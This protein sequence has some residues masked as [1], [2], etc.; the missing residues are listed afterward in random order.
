MKK[1]DEISIMN[2]F[3]G[4]GGFAE[5]NAAKTSRV[6]SKLKGTVPEVIDA[7]GLLNI[8]DNELTDYVDCDYAFIIALNLVFYEKSENQL[9][10]L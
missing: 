6:Y 10:L 7:S 5:K 8:T 4:N 1:A 2:K 3:S 9:A